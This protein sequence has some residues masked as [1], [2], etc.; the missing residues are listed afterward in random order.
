MDVVTVEHDE[1]VLSSALRSPFAVLWVT[2]TSI[3]TVVFVRN[4]LQMRSLIADIRATVGDS[5]VGSPPM[6]GP[7]GSTGGWGAE[8]SNAV[9]TGEFQG[10]MYDLPPDHLVLF[11]GAF[12]TYGSAVVVGA[13]QFWAHRRSD[14][15]GWPPFVRS[16]ALVILVQIV[17]FVVFRFEVEAAGIHTDT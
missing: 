7:T 5:G 13:T 15:A 4:L 11:L 10:R 3:W 12:V 2:I 6:F 17:V 9:W 14:H 1:S 16:M 8:L